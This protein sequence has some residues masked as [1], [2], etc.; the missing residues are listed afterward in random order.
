MRLKNLI[1]HQNERKPPEPPNFLALKTEVL[2]K[3]QF[4]P[5][6]ELYLRQQRAE[7]E[8][9]PLQ[10][11]ERQ[12]VQIVEVGAKRKRASLDLLNVLE[13][14]GLQAQALTKRQLPYR[15]EPVAGHL[16][17]LVAALERERRYVGS[18]RELGEEKMIVVLKRL[19]LD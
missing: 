14:D 7:L 13:V 18:V 4:H 17:E 19:L 15:F 16:R 9:L 10:T 1:R 2:F 3:D 8:R 11:L 5:R 12:Q 6:A